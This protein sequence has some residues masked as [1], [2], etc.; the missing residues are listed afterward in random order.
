[1][2]RKLFVRN[3]FTRKT[4]ATRRRSCSCARDASWHFTNQLIRDR[5]IP[6]AAANRVRRRAHQQKSGVLRLHGVSVHYAQ[7]VDAACST[8]VH[9]AQSHTAQVHTVSVGIERSVNDTVH[10][11][12]HEALCVFSAFTNSRYPCENYFKFKLHAV[13]EMNFHKTQRSSFTSSSIYF[14]VCV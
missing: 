5:G 13:A 2:N 4:S 7:A 8:I 6:L 9:T 11:L 1:M 3:Y 14:Y 10:N 12:P